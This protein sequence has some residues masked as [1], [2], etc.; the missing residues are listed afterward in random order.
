METKNRKM[1]IALFMSY[2]ITGILFFMVIRLRK[3]NNKNLKDIYEN[4]RLLNNLSYNTSKH[5][6]ILYEDYNQCKIAVNKLCIAIELLGLNSSPSIRKTTSYLFKQKKDVSIKETNIEL[7]NNLIEEYS[8][9][10][11]E[12]KIRIESSNDQEEKERLS[13]LF[14]EFN[15]LVTLLSSVSP[16]SSEEYIKQIYAEISLG[17][18]KIRNF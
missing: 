3:K 4:I 10:I 8:G 5:Q 17:I 15:N 14:E 9:C 7:L 1:K 11:K 18:N 6:Q 12:I 2:I 16:D 13:L